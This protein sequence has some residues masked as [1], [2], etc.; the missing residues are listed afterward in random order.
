MFIRFVVHNSLTYFDDFL[1]DYFLV[2][3]FLKDNIIKCSIIKCLVISN[4]TIHCFS[5]YQHE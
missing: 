1:L 5:N 4:K 3:I 2:M